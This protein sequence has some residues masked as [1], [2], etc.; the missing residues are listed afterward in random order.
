MIETTI[1]FQMS[2]LLFVALLGYLM[3]AK[4]NQSVVIAEI[5]VGFIIGPSILGLIT[6]TDFVKSLAHIG[7][8]ILMFVIGI[9][10][11]MREIYNLRNT[12]V[13]LCGVV[14]PWIAGYYLAIYS[15]YSFTT[16]VFIGTALTATSIAIT[17]NV[18]REMNKLDTE[19]AKIII[20]AAV[21]DDI[22]GLLALSISNELVFGELSFSLL[23]STLLKASGFILIGS[24]V[25]QKFF[26]KQ[27]AKI[28]QTNLAKRY[29]EFV[30]ISAMT[31]AF[32]YSTLAEMVGLSAI[33][34][35]FIA[36][37]SMEGIRLNTSRDFREGA[38]YLY[39]IF[40]SLFFISLGI[41]AEIHTIT[42]KEIIFIAA[43]IIIAI[44]TKVIGCGLAA[45]VQGMNNRDSLIVGFGMS[46]RGEVAMIVGLIGLTANIID[47]DIYVSIITMSLITTIITPIVLRN[48]FYKEK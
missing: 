42:L 21:I 4:I 31:I 46:P 39:I 36:G 16:S 40:A 26:N 7:A 30:F 17:A 22:L 33:V 43:L 44:L 34:G 8:V 19:V 6:Y 11:K 24:F 2:L 18:L 32:F 35:A 1:E 27:L 9:E 13:A 14:V 3:A 37:V 29:P 10:F 15:G 38:E 28:D 25:G 47:Q 20:G 5:I 45:R 48:W 12:I 23:F 41:I